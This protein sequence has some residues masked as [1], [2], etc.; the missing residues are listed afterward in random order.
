MAVETKKPENIEV[1]FTPPSYALKAKAPR[2]DKDL[3]SILI[4]VEQGF[5]EMAG[6]YLDYARQDAKRL[7]AA[8]DQLESSGG[9]TEA[10]E[11]V[12]WIADQMKG[13]GST[14]G[15]PLIT[16]VGAS[17]CHLLDA[18]KSLDEAQVQAVRLHFESMWM[19]VSRPL[20]GNSSEGVKM[21]DGLH[22]V[23][24]KVSGGPKSPPTSAVPRQSAHLARR[25][26][27]RS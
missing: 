7:G 17:L 14:F 4:E 19:V 25:T 24:A 10:I 6:D 3:D 15:Y 13:Q 22:E 11:T 5:A 18:R 9:A 1:K 27:K 16:A 20:R 8:C 12:Y 2:S 21:V 23:V 26:P